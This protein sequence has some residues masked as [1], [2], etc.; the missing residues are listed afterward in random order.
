[1]TNE[2]LPNKVGGPGWKWCKKDLR[3]QRIALVQRAP[4]MHSSGRHEVPAVQSSCSLTCYSV[5][6]WRRFG[7]AN[8]DKTSPRGWS[9]RW[10]MLLERCYKAWLQTKAAYSLYKNSVKLSTVDSSNAMSFPIRLS[11]WC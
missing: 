6:G 1:V 3:R 11:R 4:G 9:K 10:K 7:V 2:V 8:D 5:C